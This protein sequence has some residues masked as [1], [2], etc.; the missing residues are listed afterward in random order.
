MPMPSGGIT[1]VNVPD[2]VRELGP[3]ILIGSG[4]GVHGHPQGPEAGAQAFRK[5]IEATMKGVPLAEA[6]KS[7]EPLKIALEIWGKVTEFK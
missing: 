1:Q 3:E 6:A 7:N 4:G 5:A 2:I